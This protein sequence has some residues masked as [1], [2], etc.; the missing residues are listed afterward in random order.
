MDLSLLLGQQIIVIAVMI[1]M[2]FVAGKAKL[3]DMET[4]AQL[5]KAVLYIIAPCMLIDAFQIEFSKEKVYGFL[6]SL[7]AAALIHVVL[8]LVAKLVCKAFS[9]KVIA[10][11]SII[12]T[13]CG[14]LLV[15]IVGYMLGKEY[16]LYCSSY[17]IVQNILVW[18]Y[19]IR[20]ISGEKKWN[21]K[22]IVLNPNMIAIAVGLIM[23]F[24]NITLPSFLGSA[25]S[26]VGDCVGPASMIV[27]GIVISTASLKEVFLDKQTWLVTIARLFLCPMVYILLLKLCHISMISPD[28]KNILFV[29]FLAVATPSASTVSQLANIMHKEEILAGSINIMTICLCMATMPLMT[30]LYQLLV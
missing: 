26:R 4:S 6:L 27:I 2:G 29:S 11:A 7:V 28:A 13:N 10:E 15:P 21:I 18:S 3:V 23:F 24:G 12:Y 9:L 19:G 30:L 20:M 16:V 25:V 1:V 22:K 14:N 8:I 17:I 5:A